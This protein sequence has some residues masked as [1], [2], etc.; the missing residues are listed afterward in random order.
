MAVIV[1]D[2]LGSGELMIETARHVVR[3]KEV[4]SKEA[5][6]VRVL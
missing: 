3:E 6:H 5:G 2:R 1:E 4:L